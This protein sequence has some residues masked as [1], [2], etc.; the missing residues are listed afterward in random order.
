LQQCNARPRKQLGRA[1][2]SKYRQF[3]KRNEFDFSEIVLA[4]SEIGNN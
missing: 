2:A 4:L 1:T 3:E